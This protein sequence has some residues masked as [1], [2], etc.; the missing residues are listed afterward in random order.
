MP[1]ER[2]PPLPWNVCRC[3]GIEKNVDGVNLYGPETSRKI[4]LTQIISLLPKE[5]I[6]IHATDELPKFVCGDCEITLN[7]FSEF[8]DMVRKAQ[9]SLQIQSIA[10]TRP[11]DPPP[12]IDKKSEN[13]LCHTL[14][15][16][17]NKS[18]I[19]ILVEGDGKVKCKVCGYLLSY[20]ELSA[21]DLATY[22]LETVVCICQLCGHRG[23]VESFLQN[24]NNTI[25]CSNCFF[26]D[27]KQP[28]DNQNPKPTKNIFEC[29]ICFKTFRSKSHYDRHKMIHSG[30]KPFLCETCGTGFNQKKS[31]KLHML[32]HSGVNP[33]DCKWCG[34]SFRYK[35]SLES[36]VIN[37]HSA[38]SEKKQ[39]L[40]CDRCKKQFAT[41]YKL[42]RHHRSHTGVRP[43]KCEV[44]DRCFS[45]T[46]NLK[47]HLKKHKT[48][49]FTKT[50]NTDELIENTTLKSLE[51]IFE[52]Q[53]K[54]FLNL[55]KEPSQNFSENNVN[56]KESSTDL[57][58]DFNPQ[59][60]LFSEEP[61]NSSTVLPTFKAIYRLP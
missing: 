25:C 31:L 42:I 3:C 9:K 21:L 50:L 44:C 60:V 16:S 14:G 1:Q 35:E 26:V 18:P 43:Y 56:G 37:I 46:G 13:I 41:K 52:E 34:Q 20:M 29:N 59:E 4:R 27:F 15:N 39:K 49:D 33:Y 7:H 55:D 2:L 28:K 17:A 12:Y 8:C 58:S 5:I 19:M 40:E 53:Q 38:I 24:K 57:F 11:P 6:H 23:D 47:A 51:T 48:D 22:N 30:A 54:E 61:E 32:S 45:Q 10:T 36:H